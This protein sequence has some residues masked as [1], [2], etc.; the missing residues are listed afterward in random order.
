MYK[1]KNPTHRHLFSTTVPQNSE[2]VLVSKAETVTEVLQEYKIRWKERPLWIWNMKLTN[3]SGWVC[4]EQWI[5]KKQT[6]NLF[7]QKKLSLFVLP[8]I[9]T[10][11]TSILFS[12]YSYKQIIV[13]FFFSIF[14]IMI[15]KVRIMLRS[16][17]IHHRC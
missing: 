5:K 2:N 4:G 3:T 11:L 12:F 6:Q 17:L 7:Q 16:S 1:K 10:L 15:Y 9:Y 13:S 8:Q 14:S